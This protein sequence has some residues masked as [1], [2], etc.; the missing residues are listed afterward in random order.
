MVK[1]AVHQV[2]ALLRLRT[3]PDFVTFQTFM[4]EYESELINRLVSAT[5][6]HAVYR[7]QG[8]LGVLRDLKSVID[9]APSM[10]EKLNK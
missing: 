1:L 5:D 8:G 10:F 9:E 6:P 7:A 3:V 4:Q 2:E